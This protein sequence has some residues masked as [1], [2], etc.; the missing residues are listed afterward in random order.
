MVAGE[1][2][3]RIFKQKRNVGADIREFNLQGYFL[4]MSPGAPHHHFIYV[5][6]HKRHGKFDLLWLH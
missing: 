6:I 4:W 1:K 3:L 5:H 2:M